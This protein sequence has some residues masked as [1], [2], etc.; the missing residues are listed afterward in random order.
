[1]CYVSEVGYGEPVEPELADRLYSPRG[2]G[3]RY[4][5][6]AD[7]LWRRAAHF[8]VCGC[9]VRSVRSGQPAAA[10]Q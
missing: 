1:M 7:G 4:Q 8:E 10:A 2:M 3:E 5:G 9:C 6:V